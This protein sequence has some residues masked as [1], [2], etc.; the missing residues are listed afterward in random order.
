M[1]Y[2]T[3][4][5]VLEQFPDI[6]GKLEKGTISI[7]MIEE[8]I[9]QAEGLINGYIGKRYELPFETPPDFVVSLA[10]KAFEFFYLDATHIPSVTGQEPGFESP[11]WRRLLDLLEMIRD[12][13]LLL[14]DKDK[15]AI[16]PSQEKLASIISNKENEN[17]IFN[18]KDFWDQEV[19]E[20]YDK[21]P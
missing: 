19:S 20:S 14:Y 10:Y 11:K 13:N 1:Y 15:K 5:G 21:E 3:I 18:M 12:G 2:I 17:Q 7:K 9:L 16:P 6:N 4:S 8:W